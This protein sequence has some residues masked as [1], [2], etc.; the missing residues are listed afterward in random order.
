M[1]EI[2]N[3]NRDKIIGEFETMKAFELSAHDLYAQIAADPGV[4]EP[5]VRRVFTEL[6]RDERRHAA[7]V[8]E[9]I[10]LANNAL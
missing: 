6:A 7:L 4:T 2:K 5:G 1:A 8:Q 10:D 3:Q 9:I